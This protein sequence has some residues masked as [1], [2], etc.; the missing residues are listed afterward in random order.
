MKMR[1]PSVLKLVLVKVL[2]TE[3]LVQL[4]NGSPHQV[5]WHATCDECADEAQLDQIAKA[6]AVDL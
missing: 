6:N 3:P 4:D 5:E 2:L 1:R